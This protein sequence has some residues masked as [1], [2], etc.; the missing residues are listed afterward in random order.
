M[1]TIKD[2]DKYR[3]EEGN[4]YDMVEERVLKEEAIEW[5]KNL[6]WKNTEYPTILDALPET[7][8]GSA[9]A[10]LWRET[11]FRL[12]AEYGMISWIMYFFNITEEDLK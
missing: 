11:E 10:K 2:L 6:R 12:G 1:K 9:P 5:I 4:V 3:C 7:M 8:K